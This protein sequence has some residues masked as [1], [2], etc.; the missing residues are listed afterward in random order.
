MKLRK[1]GQI[2]FAAQ[3][4]TGL[5]RM[6]TFGIR[7]RHHAIDPGVIP[8]NI[9]DGSREGSRYIYTFWHEAMLI[10]AV[11]YGRP[12]VH[13]LISQHADGELITEIIRRFNFSVVRGSTT[14]G[15]LKAM[16]E[17]L[18]IAKSNHLAITPDGPRGPR[19]VAQQGLVYLA[20]RTGLPI[21]PGGFA[22]G[23]CW[24][25]KS[26]DRFMVPK[27][28]TTA[29]IVSGTPIQIPPKIK[30]EQI[31]EQLARVQESMDSLTSA[32][33]RWAETGVRPGG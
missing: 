27:P 10:P 22:Y 12:D 21:V 31:D 28:L 5:L 20:S 6:M 18:R 13:V 24:R 29:Y 25:A 9:N 3:V 19:R 15:A 16:R 30:A 4:G 26:W 8:A 17:M 1:P 33:E 23:R 7:Y 32:A 2:R 11:L 14:R